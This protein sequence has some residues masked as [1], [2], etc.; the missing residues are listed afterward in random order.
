MTYLLEDLTVIDAA[1]YLAGPAASTVMADYGANVIKIEPPGGDGYRTLVGKYPV[2][3]H[4]L[5]TS[6]NKKSVCLDLSVPAGQAVLHRLVA[7]ADVLTTNFLQPTLKRY[8]MT[9]ERLRAINPRL[10]FGHITGYG[11]EGPDVARRAFDVTAWWG[12]TGLMEFI[13]ER[14]GAAQNPAP[15]MGDHASSMSFFGAIMAGL[16]R[17]ERTGEGAYVATSLLANGV[18]QNGMAL[19]GVIAGNDLGL[20]KQE[21]GWHN[22]FTGVYPTSDG[23]YVV[24]AAI[25]AGREW[26]KICDAVGH[27][28]WRDDARFLDL[29]SAMKNRMELIDMLNRAFAE[30]TLAENRARLDA[31]DVTY[32]WAQPM[33]DVI[34]DE[35]VRA[36]GYVVETGDDGEG[37]DLT[38]ASPIQIAE[39][40]K[41]PPERAPDVGADSRTVLEASGFSSS[42][43]DAL[44]EQSVVRT[45]GQ[46]EERA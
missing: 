14:G 46:R 22:P 44:I 38:I 1:S 23:G 24:L 20:H 32:G 25:N 37:Y 5:L 40:N 43:V 34:H 33:G 45:A 19:Q 13:R 18:W 16:Y 8:D 21:K 2:P 12:R 7:Q 28:E 15:G 26:P 36:N 42:E 9:Y 6:R 39:E 35:Q 11:T 31:A 10:I 17:R 3:Y 4:W 29:A 27:P 30:R 41:R